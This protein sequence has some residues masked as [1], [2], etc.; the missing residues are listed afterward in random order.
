MKHTDIRLAV[1]AALSG[2]IACDVTFF[3]G[4]PAVIEEDDFPAVAV[5]LTDAGYTGEILDAD[6]WRALLHIEVFLPAQVPDSELDEWMEA[7]IYPSLGDIPALSG[8]IT[9]MVQ[10]GYDYQRDEGLGLWSSADLKYS[11]TYEM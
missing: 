10:Q 11:I 6:V 9:L 4:R 3:D 5:Y 8:L 2:G 1:I 7:Y